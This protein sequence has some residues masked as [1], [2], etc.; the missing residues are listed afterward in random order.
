ML[1]NDEHIDVLVPDARTT[2]DGLEVRF[3]DL[4]SRR[5]SVKVGPATV[6]IPSIDDLILTK[7]IAAPDSLVQEALSNA[8][9]PTGLRPTVARSVDGPPSS[10]RVRLRFVRAAEPSRITPRLYAAS[11]LTRYGRSAASSCA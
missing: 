1:E 5:V 4:W 6:F 9:R 3:S 10:R 7:R 11:T 2:V 8:R